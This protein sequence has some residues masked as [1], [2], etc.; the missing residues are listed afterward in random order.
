MSGSFSLIAITLP[1]F[2]EQ[3]DRKISLLLRNGFDRVHIRKPDWTSEQVESLLRRIPGELYPRLTLHQTPEVISRLQ[4][5]RQLGFQINGRFPHFPDCEGPKS[6]SCHSLSEAV[7]CSEDPAVS[8]Q[9]LSPIFDSISKKG[10]RSKFTEED[11]AQ[12]PPRTIALGGVT[13]DRIGSLKKLGFAGAAFLGWV[14]QQFSE[15]DTESDLKRKFG[16]L[17][18][19]LREVPDV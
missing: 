1:D 7:S 8:Y 17:M 4:G 18:T 14:W 5:G 16:V 12:V 11:L 9:T 10:Y 19:E 13:P 3:E 15:N 6:V 2:C